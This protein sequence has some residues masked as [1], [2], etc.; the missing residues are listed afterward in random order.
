MEYLLCSPPTAGLRL[1]RPPSS[2]DL[3]N[4]HRLLEA[5][6]QPS[7]VLLIGGDHQRTAPGCSDD[8]VRVDDIRGSCAAK[9]LSYFVHLFRCE[10]KDLA[11]LQ[12]SS[13]LDLSAR[14]ADLGDHRCGGHRDDAELKPGAM[15]GP[16]LSVVAICRDQ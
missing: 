2:A 7:Q 9:K 4:G 1:S 15:I 6:R 14:A 5:V 10:R 13:E 8:H 3:V 12:E 11:P 16:H